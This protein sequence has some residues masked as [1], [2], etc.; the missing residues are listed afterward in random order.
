MFLALAPDLNKR[1]KGKYSLSKKIRTAM[2]FRKISLVVILLASISLFSCNKDKLKQLEEKNRILLSQSQQQDSLLTDFLS[3]F[4][5]FEDNLEQIK[6]RENL[7]SMESDDPELRKEGKDKIL[8]DIQMIDELMVQNRSLID[9]LEQKVKNADSKLGQYRNMVARLNR[10]MKERDNDIVSLKEALVQR[11]FS[12]EELNLK[13]DTLNR[14][15]QD[16]NVRF[17]TQTARIASQIQTIETQAETIEQQTTEINTAYFVAG[18]SKDLKNRNILTTE[19]GFLGIGGV[20]KLGD[21]LSNDE[22]IKIDIT[23]VTSIPLESKKSKVI[24]NH[25]SD[26]YVIAEENDTEVLE[27]TNPEKFWKNTKYLV[28]VTN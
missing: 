16:L 19:G 27:I 20:K 5:A 15:N 11:D 12:I 2:I 6:D 25:P 18:S 9:E 21:N 28:V 13:L 24:T 10:Q 14:V 7:I 8:S 17:E 26:S 22:F 23:E 4:N 1:G 3:S